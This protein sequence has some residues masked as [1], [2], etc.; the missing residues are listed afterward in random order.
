MLPFFAL[1]VLFALFLGL[2]Q[3]G[4][5]FFGW[6]TSLRLALTGMFLLTATAHWG[7]RRPDLIRMVPPAFPRPD[8]IVTATGILELL[9]AVGLTVPAT[10]R[11]AA[12]G[13]C[14]LLLAMFPAN[15]HAAR[16]GLTIAGKS[17]PALIPRTLLQI[18]F[19]AATAVVCLARP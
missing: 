19:V 15:V 17:V 7:K 14:L 18:V 2:G 16:Q 5:A 10:A 4:L 1:I 6:W 13:L 8:L 9:G 12:A 11:F 3:L